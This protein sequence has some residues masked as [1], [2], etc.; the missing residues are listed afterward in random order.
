MTEQRR[1]GLCVGGVFLAL[2]GIYLMT[3]PGR[4]DSIDGQWRYEAARNW[5][6]SGDPHVTDRYLLYTRGQVNSPSSG[7]AYTVY[8]AAPSIA[9]MPL[10]ILS[11]L[12]PG[13]TTERDH[14][15]FSFTGP[16][17][18]AALGAL[19]MTGFGWMGIGLRRSLI[20]TSLFCLTTLWWPASVTVLDQNQHAVLMLAAVLVGWQSGRRRSPSL[21]GLAGIL[22]GLLVNY[23]EMYLL[24]LPAL[25]LT[26]L[27][28]PQ[29]GSEAGT[30]DAPQGGRQAVG[31][32]LLM[33]AGG[34]CVGLGCFAGFNLMRY[35]VPILLSR[36]GLSSGEESPGGPSMWGDP[37]AGLLSLAS[38]PGKGIFWFSPL[39]L[40]MLPAIRKLLARAPALTLAVVAASIIHLLVITRLSFFGGDWCWGPRYIIPILPLWALAL[41]L[42]LP[43]PGSSPRLLWPLA[44]AG[45]LIQLMG[46]SLDHHRFFFERN[47]PQYFWAAEPWIYFQHSQLLARPGEIIES[48]TA[49]PLPEPVRFSPSPTGQATYCPFGPPSLAPPQEWVRHHRIFYLPR[50]WWGW[51]GTLPPQQ[52]PIDPAWLFGLCAASLA[53]GGSL[54]ARA[55]RS[56]PLDADAPGTLPD[57]CADGPVLLSPESM[58]VGNS[59]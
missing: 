26:V 33:F 5:L 29:E 42:V 35:G 14:I 7:R 32:R 55:L 25:G 34:G 28:S 30:V 50:C 48:L 59:L 18:G 31:L 1:R 47:L 21:A 46:I 51:I 40:L 36:Y 41:P 10:M 20:A 49:G 52:R 44:A 16:I 12:V 37:L 57:N 54:L 3:A 2:L 39:L 58:P 43:C 38:S 6:D 23:Q 53:V 17:F 8:N 9:A 22:A 24:L 27:A 56:Q 4:I 19:L 15:L 45:L 11:R 13:H